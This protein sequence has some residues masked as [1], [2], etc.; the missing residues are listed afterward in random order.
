MADI[1]R[2]GRLRHSSDMC[3]VRVKMIESHHHHLFLKR[4]FLPRSA[5]V[6]RLPQYEAS[7]HIPEHCRF[8]VQTKLVRQCLLL[9][10]LSMSSCPCPHISPLPTPHFYRPHPIISILTF[11]MPK[12]PQSTIPHHFCHALNTRKTV[13]VLT[14]LPILQRHTTHPSHHH[15]LCSLQ[16]LQIFSLH[17]PCLCLL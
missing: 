5:R 13:Q 6:R 12:P 15:A 9:H 1:V 4:P 16:A 11:H 3:S 14:S 2:H 10:I 8:R 17:C 7:P